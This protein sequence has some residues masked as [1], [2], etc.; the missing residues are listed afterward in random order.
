MRQHIDRTP[1]GRWT[2]GVTGNPG[3][4]PKINADVAS[5]LEA[6]SLAA[7]QRLVELVSSEDERVALAAS[8]ALLDRTLGKAPASLEVTSAPDAA[9]WDRVQKAMQRLTLEHLEAVHASE[10][11]HDLGEVP[12]KALEAVLVLADAG[13]FR[14]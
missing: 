1:N 3:G 6:G 9:H 7:A 2:P 12:S 14:G 8:M 11:L 13:A 5:A 10:G 4:R